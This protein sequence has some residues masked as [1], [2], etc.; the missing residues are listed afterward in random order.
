MIIETKGLSFSWGSARILED[1]SLHAADGRLVGI[2]GPNGSGKSTF[3]KCVYRVL[4]PNAGCIRLN[5]EEIGRMGYKETAKLL[6]VVAQHNAYDFDFL[7]KD[8]VLMGRAPHK[9]A[10]DSDTAEDYAIMRESLRQVGMETMEDRP[11]SN[12]SGGEQQRVILARTLAQRTQALILDEPTN[13]LDVKYQLQL[14]DIVKGMHKT[15]LAAFHDLN[16]A[17]MYS[18]EI[19][20]LKDGRIYSH[21][22]PQEVMTERMIAEVYGVHAKVCTEENGQIYIVYRARCL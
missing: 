7:V 8:M 19:Y 10:L 18:D 6:G 14:L 3:L 9:R 4:R 2:I 15:V 17:A 21:G 5:G 20:V 16:L 12:L 22:V 11:F 13:H 1:V